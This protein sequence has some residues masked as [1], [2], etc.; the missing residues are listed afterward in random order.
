MVIFFDVLFGVCVV[1]SFWFAGY[2]VYRV[3]NDDTPRR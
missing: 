1:A 3:L 2:V